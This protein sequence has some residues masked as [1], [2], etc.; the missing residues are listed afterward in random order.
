MLGEIIEKKEEK[1]EWNNKNFSSKLA[2]KQKAGGNW[3]FITINASLS[4]CDAVLIY[5][6]FK[7]QHSTS[8][9]HH[10]LM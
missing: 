8:V 1:N 6:S 4:C 3:G 5:T 10:S 2:K 9:F 7:E